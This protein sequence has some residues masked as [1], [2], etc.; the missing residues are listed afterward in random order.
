[1]ATKT[2][3]E[4][5]G[6]DI[7]DVRD[8]IERVEELREQR[9]PRFVAGWNMPGYLP[10]SEP[11]EF[12][13]AEDAKRYIIEELKRM[14]DSTDDESEAEALAAFAEDVNLESDEF[15]AQCG[16]Y[17]YFVTE[18]G[19]MGLDDE[20]KSELEALES[21]LSDLCGYGGDEQW[22]GDW[23]PVTLIL[24][25]YFTK[26]AEELC[27]DIGDLP[28]DIPSYL[29]IDW[30]ATAKNIQQDY[31]SIDFDGDTYWYR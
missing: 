21:L 16:I 6:E 5:K 14:E 15:S 22:E 18:D 24:D 30:D 4:L 28:K 3:E 8:V 23:Y 7:I 20:E 10:D 9:T 2:I 25:S 17:V 26:Y 31:S 1:M 12:S 11:A 27:S 19:T 13:D 29:V